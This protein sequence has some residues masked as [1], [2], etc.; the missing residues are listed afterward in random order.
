MLKKRATIPAGK[1]QHRVEYGPEHICR[2]A[3]VPAFRK[4]PEQGARAAAQAVRLPGASA[5]RPSGRP[6][7]REKVGNGRRSDGR[8]VE[9]QAERVGPSPFGGVPVIFREP[10]HH[11]AGRGHR[12]ASVKTEDGIRGK[13]RPDSPGVRRRDRRGG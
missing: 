3:W 10:I 7:A 1:Q 5:F 2:G 8:R 13:R 6:G 11:H 12:A 9:L 4:E